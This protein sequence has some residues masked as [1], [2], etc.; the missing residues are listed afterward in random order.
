MYVCMNPAQCVQF[1]QIQHV[2]VGNYYT[3]PSRRRVTG[4]YLHK[5]LLIDGRITAE[6]T[7]R[8][9]ITT[10]H[11]S[12]KTQPMDIWYYTNSYI[13]DYSIYTDV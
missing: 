12:K 2:A 1:S 5:T 6:T 7:G 9:Q 10:G 3:A 4:R 8:L 11:M 13:N